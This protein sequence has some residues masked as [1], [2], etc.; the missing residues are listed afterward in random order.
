MNAFSRSSVPRSVLWIS[1]ILVVVILSCQGSDE[2][3][4]AKS[5]EQLREELIDLQAL[6]AVLE[7]RIELGSE[8]DSYLILDLP[9]RELRLELQ[10]VDLARYPIREISMNRRTRSIS[11]DTARISFCQHPFALQR[12]R[13]YEQVR[14]LALK[15]STA[16]GSLPDTTG[17][18]ARQIT[19]SR[20]LALLDFDRDLVVALHG[21]R[22]PR[23]V[24]DHF[25]ASLSSIA[26]WVRP[27]SG[28]GRRAWKRTSTTFIEL[29]MEP[30]AVRSLAPNLREGTR[31]ILRF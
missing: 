16:I 25:L 11:Q 10:G 27:G 17:E 20:V 18:L 29:R 6:Q 31:L 26:R 9:E 2:G 7:A 5:I 21:T 28:E 14:T 22:N 24:F 1:V 4:P 30:A 8:Q 12:D 13:W 3:E 23:N 19:R 15:D